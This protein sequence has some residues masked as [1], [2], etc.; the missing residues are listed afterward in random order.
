MAEFVK[1]ENC[2]INLDNI[3]CIDYDYNRI[4]FI[5]GYRMDM[6]LKAMQKFKRILEEKMKE[7]DEQW[8]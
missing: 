2:Q 1:I 3:I 6:T 4:L 7:G 8:L 5:G